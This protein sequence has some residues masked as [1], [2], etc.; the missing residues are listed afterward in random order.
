MLRV[1]RYNLVMGKKTVFA[2]AAATFFVVGGAVVADHFAVRAHVFQVATRDLRDPDRTEIRN[3]TVFRLAHPLNGSPAWIAC[4]EVNTPNGFGGM[5]GFEPFSAD[6][7]GNILIIP[8][9]VGLDVQQRLAGTCAQVTLPP[10]ST[11][12]Y[13]LARLGLPAGD[14]EKA[15]QVVPTAR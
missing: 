8:R 2:A 9:S 4:G 12:R 15:S 7:A 6:S 10:F 11:A 14:T 13:A 3:V 1:R 5:V